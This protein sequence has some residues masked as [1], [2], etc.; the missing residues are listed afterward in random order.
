VLLDEPCHIV[1]RWGRSGLEA[2]SLQMRV[3]AVVVVPA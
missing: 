2:S 3:A 1:L